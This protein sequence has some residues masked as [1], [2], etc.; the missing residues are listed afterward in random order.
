MANNEP[1]AS[2]NDLIVFP[3]LL[4]GGSGTRLWP[5]SRSQAP[6][7]LAAFGGRLSLL[8]ETIQRLSPAVNTNN[9]IIVCGQDHRLDSAEHLVALGIAPEEIGVRGPGL[10][11]VLCHEP[12]IGVQHFTVAQLDLL[13]GLA[14]GRQTHDPREVLPEIE[15]IGTGLRLGDLRWLKGLCGADGY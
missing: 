15:Y 7:Q 2:F 3:V 5:V 10:A 9:V 14:A 13:A 8:Q 11:Q 4:A 1:K 6:K 12:A